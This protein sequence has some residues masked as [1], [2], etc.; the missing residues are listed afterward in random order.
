MSSRF[1]VLLLLLLLSVVEAQS[2]SSQFPTPPQQLAPWSAPETVPTNLL[3]A[4]TTVFAQGFPDPRGCEYRQVTIEVG[5]VCGDPRHY[6]VGTNAVTNLPTLRL[7]TRGWVLPETTSETRRFAICWS[8]LIYPVVEV[9]EPVSLA[10]EVANMPAPRWIGRGF[11]MGGNDEIRSVFATN[12][13]ATRILLLLRSGFAE[14]A[15]TNWQAVHQPQ[16]SLSGPRSIPQSTESSAQDPYLTFA[17]DWAWAMFDRAVCAHMRGAEALALAD[18]QTLASVQP[19]IEAEAARRGFPRQRY[20]DSSRQNREQPYLAFLESLPQLLSDLERRVREGERLPALTR[21]L[22][23]WPSAAERIAVLVR[24]L[25]LV[26]ARQWMQPGGVSL[27]DDPVVL[28]LVAE[29]D[30]AV[31]A[32]IECLATDQ[33]LTRSVSFG[34]DF[35][36]GRNLIPVSN[37]AQA[38]LRVILQTDLPTAAAW[39][40][41]WERFHGMRIEERWFTL[42]QDDRVGMSG[43]REA[44]NSIT[45]PTNLSVLMPSYARASLP[46][47]TNPPVPLSGEWLRG[48][49]HPSVSEVLARRALEIV[50][51][52]AASYDF[53]TACEIGLSLA[54]WELAAAG[55]VATKLVQRH[56][57]QREYSEPRAQSWQDQRLGILLAALTCVRARAGEAAPFAEY[58][59]W[60]VTTT[61]ENNINYLEQSLAPLLEFP[62]N[63]VIQSVAGQLFGDT[64]SLWGRLPWKGGGFFNPIQTSLVKLPA[65]RQLLA[66][67]LEVKTICGSVTWRGPETISIQLTNTA[68]FSGSRTL[69]LAEA[70]RP[71]DG[72]SA[73]LRWCDWVAFSLAQTGQIPSFNPF[74]PPEQRD[75][76][77]REAKDLLCKD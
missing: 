70:E 25:D 65:F 56:Q 50:P 41:Y 53:T 69:K 62:K 31:P 58:A 48:K 15:V 13:G 44:A 57:V 52:N 4:A 68:N 29:G 35:Q 66:R 18:A 77:T 43:W 26:A 14:A 33:R 9:G 2:E 38:A 45:R 60:L 37:A 28:A 72:A 49:A 71:A 8:G 46:A 76:L 73:E 39:R 22:T 16:L 7:P 11:Y 47:A 12:A 75:R 5:S 30:P 42:L 23:N 64:N 32:L 24:D 55:P 59:D 21:G 1:A 34:R 51:T 40:A 54:R 3:S 19:K 36:R 10:D 17:G 20:Y 67:E 61:P 27:T 63:P 6:R 74:A